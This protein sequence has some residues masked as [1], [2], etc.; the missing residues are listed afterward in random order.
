M[1]RI[2][3]ILFIL[4]WWSIGFISW[5]RIIRKK[6]DFTLLHFIAGIFVGIFP[7]PILLL[8]L[9]EDASNAVIEKKIDKPQEEANDETD[10]E[11]T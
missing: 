11:G 6:Y 8:W 5:R 9:I 7:G 10:E 3:L 2:A 4:G 1:A